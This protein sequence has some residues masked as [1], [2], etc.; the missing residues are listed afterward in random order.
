MKRAL[1]AVGFAAAVFLGSVIL[2]SAAADPA[3]ADS[4]K[5]GDGN[6]PVE[7]LWDTDNLLYTANTGSVSARTFGIPFHNYDGYLR[8]EYA[9]PCIEYRGLDDS[10]LRA[11]LYG[12]GCPVSSAPMTEWCLYDRGGG[13]WEYAQPA[14]A[15]G[16]RCPNNSGRYNGTLYNATGA[17][18]CGTLRNGRWGSFTVSTSCA[19]GGR[20]QVSARSHLACDSGVADAFFQTVSGGRNDFPVLEITDPDAE[21]SSPALKDWGASRNT[22]C[23]EFAAAQDRLLTTTAA[24]GGYYLDG[25][26]RLAQGSLPAHTASTRSVNQPRVTWQSRTGFGQTSIPFSVSAPAGYAARVDTGS[27]LAISPS[28]TSLTVPSPSPSWPAAIDS[29]TGTATWGYLQGFNVNSHLPLP[30]A[31]GGTSA[32]VWCP[33]GFHPRGEDGFPRVGR[34]SGRTLTSLAADAD[35]YLAD[36]YW[37]RS[38]VRYKIEYKKQTHS[39]TCGGNSRPCPA[40]VSLPTDRFNAFGRA[41]CYYTV[42]S[43]DTADRNTCQYRHPVPRCA[44]PDTSASREFSAAELAT[45]TTSDKFPAKTD[46]TTPCAAATV[47]DPPTLADFAAGACVTVDIEIYENRPAGKDAEPGVPVSDRTLTTGTTLPPAWDLDVTSPHPKTASPPR[48]ATAGTGDASGC[49]DGSEKRADHSASPGAAARSQASATPYASSSRTDM[50]VPPNDAD[51]DID[52]SGAAANMAHRYAGLVAE[53]TCV[54]KRAEADLRLALLEAEAEI[55]KDWIGRYGD[56]AKGRKEAFAS[57]RPTGYPSGTNPDTSASS[58]TTFNSFKHAVRSQS[59]LAYASGMSNMYAARETAAVTAAA[60]V[61]TKPTVGSTWC[62][63]P[64]SFVQSYQTAVTNLKTAVGAALIAGGAT[65]ASPTAGPTST[66][67]LNSGNG[68][69]VVSSELTAG[70]AAVPEIKGRSYTLTYRDSEDN[71][72]TSTTPCLT[73]VPSFSGMTATDNGECVSQAGSPEVLASGSAS[74]VSYPSYSFTLSGGGWSRTVTVP[75]ATGTAVCTSW[76][77]S[78]CYAAPFT[79]PDHS[80]SVS[81]A[82]GS[83]PSVANFP[84]LVSPRFSAGYPAVSSLLGEYHPRHASR[85]DLE[86]P[87]ASV[88]DKAAKDLGTLTLANAATT[89]PTAFAN[90]AVPADNPAEDSTETA[91]RNA[92]RTA[93]TAYQNTYTAAYDAA[94][95]QA[96]GHMSGTA[97]GSFDWRYETPTLAWADYTEDGATTFSASTA[98]PKDGTG[99]DLIAVASDGTV[100]VEATRLDFETSEY[101]NGTVFG[102]R[103]DPQRTCKV[104]RSRSPELFLMYAPDAPSGTDTSKTIDARLDSNA[105]PSHA[106]FF[107]VDYQPTSGAEKF[108]LYEE[109]EI[110]AVRTGLADTAP[111]FCWAPG[112]MKISH[113]AEGRTTGP[114]AAPGAFL[115]ESGEPSPRHTA[116]SGLAQTITVKTGGTAVPTS[117]YHDVCAGIP[118]PAASPAAPGWKAY[119]DTARSALVS[120]SASNVPCAGG[121]ATVQQYLPTGQAL[122]RFTDES[123]R[124]GAGTG[125][126]PT[127]WRTGE[128]GLTLRST[129]SSYMNA[130]DGS[131]NRTCVPVAL[132]LIDC[133]VS[134]ED[135]AFVIDIE[136][137][138]NVS[139][140]NVPADR[141]DITGP[142]A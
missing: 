88:R 70:S 4:H 101:G 68:G 116:G 63:S 16:N 3:A 95:T 17:L 84:A 35:I 45:Y 105:T 136:Q 130:T 14:N 135:V 141:I 47:P 26:G 120:L 22:G 110:F 126:T 51:D 13:S 76:Q 139:A 20:V 31:I 104:K 125:D 38:D 92:V 44:D 123:W 115:M 69:F 86:N 142:L 124:Y 117:P 78:S 114:P 50:A 99:C 27:A 53:N 128:N 30:A 129:P 91:Q 72:Q 111:T 121:A 56:W 80:S 58:H 77:T 43:L 49:A 18:L 61:L 100:T 81:Q 12:G 113:A 83:I 59:R 32:G 25:H 96:T 42:I 97:W 102:T 75:S 89:T 108:E 94:Y 9:K 7:K 74:S 82:R 6:R 93:A 10:V 103:T 119:D 15:S 33:A 19:S 64:S 54:A 1:A 36:M 48:D 71:E 24:N 55:Y 90:I 28:G 21:E 122:A 23:D 57:W 109:A 134:A 11:S 118:Q 87:T 8:S 65:P 5:Q 133:S 73:F 140:R 39:V 127:G 131:G 2:W 137:I 106:E 37:C 85:T 79:H 107:Y 29:G 46:G 62:G 98:T 67:S 138:A 40:G 34:G 66:V 41:N 132:R 52:Y 60:T 112:T